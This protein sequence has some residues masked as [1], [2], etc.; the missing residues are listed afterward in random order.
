MA[1]KQNK[2]KLNLPSQNMKSDQGLLLSP[3]N[4]PES[5]IKAATSKQDVTLNL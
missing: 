2:L 3:K 4:M 5:K 1:Q